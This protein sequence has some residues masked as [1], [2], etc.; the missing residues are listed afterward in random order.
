MG[1]PVQSEDH[2]L[3][4]VDEYFPRT[5]K[6]M[7]VDRGDDCAVWQPQHKLCVSTDMFMEDVH[8]RR[9]YFSAEDVGWKA[10]A[11]NMSDLAAMGASPTGFSV[12][13]ALPPD[14]D[15][16]LVRGI[17]HG[18]AN[19]AALSG[20]PALTGGDISR[21]DKLHLCV[22]VWGEATSPLLRRQCAPGD[23]L[24]M[25]GRAG[26]ARLGLLVLEAHGT[27]ALAAWPE[28]CAAH[29]RPEPKL[30]QGV[31]L[32]ALHEQLGGRMGLM[33]LSDG[34]ARD[35]PRLLGEFGADLHLPSPHPEWRYYAE[36]QHWDAARL[37]QEQF[38]GGEEY[39]LIGTC[40]SNLAAQIMAMLPEASLLGIVTEGGILRGGAAVAG[41]D[42][43]Q[44]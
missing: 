36:Q 15:E 40:Q 2:I 39:A 9:R 30:K 43:F 25:V 20:N 11:V 27:D 26:L 16:A 14:A 41:F 28:A 10:L 35:L 4:L 3:R 22:T 6:R 21:A 44:R 33:D 5:D 29:L 42:H 17:L 37:E 32:S 31:R 7:L 34:L 8:F 13:L 1:T 23:T 24:F 19:M 38:L 12:G 18:M